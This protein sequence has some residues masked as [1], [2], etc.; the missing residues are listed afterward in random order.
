MNWVTGRTSSA[1]LYADI[2]SANE[3]GGRESFLD[4]CQKGWL[5]SID[6]LLIHDSD[7]IRG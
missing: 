6:L 7:P 1:D 3:G 5:D 2:F 4:A